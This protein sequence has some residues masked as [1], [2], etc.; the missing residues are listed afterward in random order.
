MVRY[1]YP[2][3]VIMFLVA[4]TIMARAQDASTDADLR[5]MAVMAKINQLPDDRHRFES[6]IGGYYYLGRLNAHGPSENLG[7][8]VANAFTAM[9]AADFL[10]ETARCE[11]EMRAQGAVMSSIGAAMPKPPQQSPAK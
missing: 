5:C 8:S 4:C 1:R 10:A 11:K 6:L 9:S 3:F 7:Q 2:F